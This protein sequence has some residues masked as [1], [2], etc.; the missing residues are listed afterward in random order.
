MTFSAPATS[1]LRE[2]VWRALVNSLSS[3]SVG[4]AVSAEERVL[5]G[6]TRGEETFDEE[7]RLEE[8]R[9]KER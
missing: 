8:A 9:E 6:G 4:G 5:V 1:P 2:N 3:C 7:E